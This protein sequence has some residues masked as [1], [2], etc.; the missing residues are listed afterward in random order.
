MNQV[1]QR[2]HVNAPVTAALVKLASTNGCA[3]GGSAGTALAHRLGTRVV[4]PA[5]ETKEQL[6]FLTAQGCDEIQGYLLSRPL[7]S[8]QLITWLAKYRS[9]RVLGV[10]ESLSGES[11]VIPELISLDLPREAAVAG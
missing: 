3:R 8:D 10:G 6:E 7:S 2:L 1:C 4:A 11:L 5:V 9:T